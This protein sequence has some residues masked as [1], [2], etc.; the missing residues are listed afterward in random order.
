MIR[1]KCSAATLFLVTVVVLGLVVQCASGQPAPVIRDGR[2]APSTQFL[3]KRQR[4]RD[5]KR[6]YVSD[7]VQRWENDARSS[8]RWDPNYSTDLSDA[9]KNL[10]DD[11]LLAAGEAST[12]KG[13]MMVLATGSERKVQASLPEALGDPSDDLVYTPVKPCR[14]VD[15]RIATKYPAALTGGVVYGVDVD[16]N[17][18]A[19][20][21]SQGGSSSSC[22]IPYG[23]ARAVNMTLTVT[24][25]SGYGFLNAWGLGAQPQ[26]SF[27]NYAPGWT[28]ANTAT[29]PVVP[30]SGDDFD[31]YTS[32][33]ASVVIDVV[34]YFGSPVATALDCTTVENY[35]S[36]S[37]GGWFYVDAN[38]PSGRTATGG[39]FNYTDLAQNIWL[40]SVPNDTNGW[41]VWIN[42]NS[43]GTHNISAYAVCC[44]IPGR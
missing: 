26:S 28:V 11:N 35:S 16:A 44:R 12:Y 10:S 4:I 3:E 18:G 15:T 40:N 1:S 13:M 24:N 37:T 33:N 23:V 2:A 25:T 21:V 31:V 41:R 38:C 43:G 6:A 14:I 42:N 34:G 20:F 30:G 5:D 22:G 19:F 36:V 27:V 8:G 9:L 17:L 7:I 29:I 32:A 39:G